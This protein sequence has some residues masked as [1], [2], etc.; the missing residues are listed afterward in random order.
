MKSRGLPHI[1]NPTC[2][3]YP[4]PWQKL[5][6]VSMVPPMNVWAE[7]TTNHKLFHEPPAINKSTRSLLKFLLIMQNQYTAQTAAMRLMLDVQVATT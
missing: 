7:K 5:V 6:F 2:N 4:L 3:I 1:S